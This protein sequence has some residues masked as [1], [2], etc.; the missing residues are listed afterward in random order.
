M[1]EEK[2]I[3]VIGAMQVEIEALLKTAQIEKTEER[4]SM[5]FYVGSLSGTPCVIAQCGAGKV[6]SAVC[7][8]VMIDFYAPRAILNI[9]VAGGIGKDVCIGD[10]VIATACVQYD[11]DTSAVGDQP[12]EIC[13]PPE[14]RGVIEFPCDPALSQKLLEG[15]K[16]LYGRAHLGIVATGDQFVASGEA[17]LNLNRRFGAVAC[18]M[19]GASIAHACYISHVPCAVLRSISD[20]ANES[21][22]VNFQT[23]AAE[24]AQKAQKLLAGVA[25]AL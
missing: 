15:A 3:G 11:Y 13:I 24:S 17:G 12:G 4:A 9:G 8:Q 25:K 2:P 10:I 18:E 23:F 14:G 6:N 19:E 20:N 5:R 21:G 7:A 16:S 1:C 22:K